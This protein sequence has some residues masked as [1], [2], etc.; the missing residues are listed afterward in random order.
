MKLIQL[1]KLRILKKKFRA[2]NKNNEVSINCLCDINNIKIGKKTYG[3]LNIVDWGI[4]NSKLIIG[5]YCSIADDVQ[6]LLNGEHNLNTISTFP[7]KVK[8]FGQL[9]EAG[10]KGNI[11]INDDVWI[12]R[13][14]IICSGINIG[15]GAV[16]AAGAVV[17]KDVPAYAI[18]GGNPARVIKYRF[19]ENCIDKL[20]KINIVELFDNL[21]SNN[22]ET[23]YTE[24]NDDTIDNILFLLK[25]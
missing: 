7:F 11:I 3:T 24:L 19:S 18:V 23:I 12:G 14:A 8:C 5:S 2:R 21:T 6:F 16:I 22:L 4:K 10:S 1:I 20:L 17:T 15:Q 13:N 25:R 9:K